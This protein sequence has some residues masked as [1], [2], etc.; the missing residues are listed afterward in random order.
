MSPAETEL[1]ARIARLEAV[2]EMLAQRV[3]VPLP[4]VLAHA[5]QPSPASSPAPDRPSQGVP[6]R[7]AHPAPERP[8]PPPAA[9]DAPPPPP[10][11]TGVD[12]QQVMTLL[13]GGRKLEAIRLV[14]EQSGVDIRDAAEVVERLQDRLV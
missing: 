5:A 10:V 12:E 8:S 9:Q 2:V 14:R 7:P 11:V 6:E 13:R 4:P 3:G 1:V